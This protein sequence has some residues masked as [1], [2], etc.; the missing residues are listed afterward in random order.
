MEKYFLQGSRNGEMRA[1]CGGERSDDGARWGR[2]SLNL[3]REKIL[4][5]SLGDQ[6]FGLVF[7]AI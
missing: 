3:C 5:A 6:I 4:R 1:D 7:W 2:L